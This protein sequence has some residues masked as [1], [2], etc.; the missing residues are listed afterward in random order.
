M[1]RRCRFFFIIRLVLVLLLFSFLLFILLLFCRLLLLHRLD[2]KHLP[3]SSLRRRFLSSLNLSWLFGFSN[4][5]VFLRWR[6]S[7]GATYWLRIWWV[8]GFCF[9]FSRRIGHFLSRI[10]LFLDGLRFVKLILRR[11]CRSVLKLSFETSKLF[12]ELIDELLDLISLVEIFFSTSSF[13]ILLMLSKLFLD[14]LDLGFDLLSTFSIS[15]WLFILL[16]LNNICLL[17]FR[18]L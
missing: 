3:E 10:L 11:F 18:L 5:L 17:W 8:F 14:R 13:D 4:W 16:F 9:C 7:F 12:V 2:S 6:F 1:Q 15:F